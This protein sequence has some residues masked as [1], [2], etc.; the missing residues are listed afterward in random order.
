MNLGWLAETSINAVVIGNV[1]ILHLWRQ[2]EV[3]VYCNCNRFPQVM[4][5]SF[6]T[7]QVTT[8]YNIFVIW[9]RFSLQW[10]YMGSKHQRRRTGLGL[11]WSSY[12]FSSKFKLRWLAFP[13]QCQENK[14]FLRRLAMWT[15]SN[16]QECWQWAIWRYHWGLQIWTRYDEKSLNELKEIL[17]TN[18]EK[19]FI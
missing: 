9:L 11:W 17:N 13:K 16:H 15:A 19:L 10:S 14:I 6:S 5:L 8:Y 3:A 18:C 1:W 2:A 4:L 7:T 12:V